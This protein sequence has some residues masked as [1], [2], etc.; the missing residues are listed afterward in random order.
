[1]QS[2]TGIQQEQMETTQNRA[3]QQ[4]RR[5]NQRKTSKCHG[6]GEWGH[7]RRKALVRP[8]GGAK[9]QQLGPSKYTGSPTRLK[10]LQVSR[11][12]GVRRSLNRR[13]VSGR[14]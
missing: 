8:G 5:L 9:D 7:S 11:L 4:S 3:K 12:A 14:C 10:I 1:M 6:R 13:S 2:T